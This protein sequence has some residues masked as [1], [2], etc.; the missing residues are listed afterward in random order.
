MSLFRKEALENQKD[1]LMGE[2]I[3]IQPVSLIILSAVAILVAALIVSL[4]FWGSYAR[5]ETVRGYLVPDRGIVKVYPSSTGTVSKLQVKDGDHIELG[6]PMV[7]ILAERSMESGQDVDTLLLNELRQEEK[8]LRRRIENEKTMTEGE[9]KRLLSQVQWL[10]SELVQIQQTLDYHQERLEIS[11]KRVTSAK[12][13]IDS[14]NISSHDYEKIAEEHLGLKQQF[15]EQLRQQV[16]KQSNLNEV[17]AQI[18]QLPLQ[19][20]SRIMD[21]EKTISDIRQRQVEVEGRR[22]L[23]VRAPISGHVDGVSIHDGQWL[24]QMQPIPLFAIIPDESVMLAELY[25]PTRAVGFL[26]QGQEVKVRYD[27]FPYQRYGVQAGVI[28]TISQHIL[29][30]N[31]LPIPT[32]LQ[33]PV[34]RVVVRLE[35]QTIQAYGQ[36][37]ALQAGMA[38]EADIILE[39]QS[40]FDWVL[41]PIYSLRGRV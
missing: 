22:I 37:V 2:V 17:R 19:H 34:Y 38:L 32:E 5:K 35:R 25:V 4:L 28:E 8:E 27:A 6:K 9:Q 39:E 30:P 11:E 14:K 15:Q 40:L 24:N 18:D 3:L 31:E 16:T 36:E 41:D 10:E 23:E 7:S 20:E 21:L 13:L 29:N 12:K 33:E 26:K 1:R